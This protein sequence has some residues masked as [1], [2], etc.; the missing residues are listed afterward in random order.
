MPACHES[1]YRLLPR[2]DLVGTLLDSA[3]SYDNESACRTACC[4]AT[5][6]TAYAFASGMLRLASISADGLGSIKAPC[7]LY[8][9]VMSL[10]PSS[11]VS[12]GALLSEYS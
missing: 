4:N 2:L 8:A 10:V 1:L 9:N 5:G 12:S 11:F 6:C 7:A 3:G